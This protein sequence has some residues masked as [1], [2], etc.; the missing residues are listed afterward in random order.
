MRGRSKTDWWG[1]VL[2]APDAQALAD[3]Y[4]HLTGW[5][6]SVREPNGAAIQVPG[7]TSY[8]SFDDAP[9]AR[10]AVLDRCRKL[11]RLKGRA[12]SPVLGGRYLAVEHESLGAAADSA[13][14][15]PYPEMARDER[16]QLLTAQL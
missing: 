12:H 15:C 7:T 6:V 9:D 1:V 16:R 5:P 3:F 8:L 14:Q 11:A 2:E 13:V 4:S 10:I